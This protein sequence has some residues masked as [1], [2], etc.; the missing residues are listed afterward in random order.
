M[1][2]N[3]KLRLVIYA[4]Y[5]YLVNDITNNNSNLWY[6]NKEQQNKLAEAIISQL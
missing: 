4:L 2:Q 5:I 1:Y 3:T 6:T